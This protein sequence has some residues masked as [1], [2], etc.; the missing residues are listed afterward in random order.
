[1]KS[2]Y[3]IYP[4]RQVTEKNFNFA[5]QMAGIVGPIPALTPG[6]AVYMI[7]LAK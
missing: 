6:Q 3:N 5:G 7:A 4:L 1:L 2:R